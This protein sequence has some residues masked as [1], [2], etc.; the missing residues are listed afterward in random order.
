MEAVSGK[1]MQQKSPRGLGRAGKCFMSVC[2]F[3][4]DYLEA[5][6]MVQMLTRFQDSS[7]NM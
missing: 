6:S 7:V 3:C 5:S 2:V 1:N 4:G